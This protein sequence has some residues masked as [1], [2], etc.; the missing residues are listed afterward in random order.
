MNLKPIETILADQHIPVSQQPITSVDTSLIIN[1]IERLISEAHA[2]ADACSLETKGE[3]L[4]YRYASHSTKV[5]PPRALILLT[6]LY[7]NLDRLALILGLAK[8]LPD[9]RDLY[10]SDR[11]HLY[12]FRDKIIALLSR[13][14]ANPFDSSKS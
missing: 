4:Y 3:T 10:L 7:I 6:R 9:A 14:P 5:S 13:P 11:D 2:L 12:G 1:E 8:H